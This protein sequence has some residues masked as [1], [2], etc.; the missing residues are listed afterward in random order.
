[1]LRSENTIAHALEVIF[2]ANHTNDTAFLSQQLY[3]ICPS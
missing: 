3:E 1:M 2:R